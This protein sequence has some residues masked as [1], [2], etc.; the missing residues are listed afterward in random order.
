MRIIVVVDIKNW[1]FDYFAQ[2]LKKYS[3]HEIF[4]HYGKQ[5]GYR[6]TH[7]KYDLV[8]WMVDVRPDRLISLKIPREKVIVAIRSD[9]FKSKRD[10]YYTSGKMRNYCTGFMACN[11]YLHDRLSGIHRTWLAEGGCGHVSL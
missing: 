4:I 2:A 5:N 11:K 6:F 3:K 9:V 8:L 7:N 1:A 10:Y